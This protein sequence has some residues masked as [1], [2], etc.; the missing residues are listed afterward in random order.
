MQYSDAPH[1]SGRLGNDRLLITAVDRDQIVITLA[2]SDGY[3]HKWVDF[4]GLLSFLSKTKEKTSC[5]S[6]EQEVT[7]FVTSYQ[8][9]IKPTD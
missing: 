8:E 9:W 7:L 2:R 5:P 6:W 4:S 1:I 3:K